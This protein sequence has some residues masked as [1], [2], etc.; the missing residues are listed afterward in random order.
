MLITGA[1]FKDWAI[2][3]G[4]VRLLTGLRLVLLDE[5]SLYRKIRATGVLPTAL[6]SILYEASGEDFPALHVIA[7]AIAS[8][9]AGFEPDVVIGF[10]GEAD[11]ASA[12]WPRAL[13]LH[14]DRGHFAKDPYPF[15]L[16]FD[17]LG[18]HG[19]SAIAQVNGKDLAYPVTLEGRALVSAFRSTMA[20]RL[21]LLDPFAALDLRRHFDR[22]FLLPLQTSNEVFFDAQSDYRTQFEFLYDVL[23]AAPADV[24]VIVT[25]HPFF[26][27]V[28]LRT[29]PC[30]NLDQLRLSFPNMIFF[31]ESRVYQTPSQF[32]LPRVDGVW[33]VSSGVG[34]QALLFDGI[35]GSPAGT[36]ISHFADAPTFE[37]FFDRLG[38]RQ[39]GKSEALLA[40]LLERYLVPATL[41]TDGRWLK[42][43]LT[44]RIEAAR[45][46]VKPIDGFVETADA[47][48]LMMAWTAQSADSP[49]QKT[50]QWEEDVLRADM[51]AERN[52]LRNERDAI[53]NS[54]SWRVTAPLRA[55][56]RAATGRRVDAA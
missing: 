8:Q 54:T 33:T 36:E 29:G 46:A 23:A 13:R 47:D 45:S 37:A 14:V 22:V 44:R 41:F 9:A 6:D 38:Q 25:E 19:R 10:A 39:F 53:L 30:A 12:L 11:Y 43:Y 50:E 17:H 49:L 20:A 40:W 21:K 15:S 7:D 24:G 3:S 26:E 16:Y 18:T 27:P 31:E 42:D 34:H 4:K 32:L 52:A 28:L 48:R 5:V 55:L 56:K 2:G 35:V 1:W 51:L